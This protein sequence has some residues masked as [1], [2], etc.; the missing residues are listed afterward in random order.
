MTYSFTPEPTKSSLESG[1]ISVK[2][3][4]YMYSQVSKIILKGKIEN[5]GHSEGMVKC[6]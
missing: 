1:T 3:N 5:F 6:Y 4:S 2:M